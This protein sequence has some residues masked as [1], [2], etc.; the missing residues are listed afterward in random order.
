MDMKTYLQVLKKEVQR[1]KYYL[2]GEPSGHQNAQDIVGIAVGN[3]VW[4][5]LL[6]NKGFVS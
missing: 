6:E 5:D 3:N 4:Y 1:M 2:K